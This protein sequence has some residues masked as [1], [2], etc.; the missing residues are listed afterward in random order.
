MVAYRRTL[1]P[2]NFSPRPYSRLGARRNHSHLATGRHPTYTGFQ[3]ETQCV[4]LETT[5]SA[6]RFECLVLYA[7]LLQVP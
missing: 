4:L 3:Q 5:T 7:G 1:A 2:F 6:R